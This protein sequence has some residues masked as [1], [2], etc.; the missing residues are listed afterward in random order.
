[1]AVGPRSEGRKVSPFGHPLTQARGFLVAALGFAERPGRPEAVP[2]PAWA[3]AQS[4]GLHPQPLGVKRLGILL[5][6]RV[7]LT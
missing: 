3:A 6:S 4:Q 5:C 1:M 2:S 7:R